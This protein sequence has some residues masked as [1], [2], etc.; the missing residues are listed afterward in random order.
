MKSIFKKFK[1]KTANKLMFVISVTKQNYLIG[2][3]NETSTCLL[4]YKT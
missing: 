2:H 3:K 1:V 4:E